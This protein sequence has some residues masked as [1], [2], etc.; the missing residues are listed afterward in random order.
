MTE[1][2]R[3]PKAASLPNGA[4]VMVEHSQPASGID[5]LRSLTSSLVRQH[6][7]V[8]VRNAGIDVTEFY[9]LVESISP[10]IKRGVGDEE[11]NLHLHGELY[12]L[13]A[14][15]D[16]LWFYCVVPPH[17]RGQTIL[18]DGVAVARQLKASTRFF[19]EA[20]PLE[21]KFDSPRRV[22]AELFGDL[23]IEQAAATANATMGA[24]CD[25]LGDGAEFSCEPVSNDVLRGIFRR[26]ALVTT[27]WGREPAFVNS[28]L[29]ALGLT[30]A[31][32]NGYSLNTDIP[33]HVLDDVDATTARLTSEIEWQAGDFAVLDNSR[34]M[35]GRR[36]FTGERDIRAVNGVLPAREQ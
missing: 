12:Y 26:C 3:V 20:T 29:L 7:G 25:E 27:R 31:N 8:V 5:E 24:V 11:Q 1:Q 14:K 9:A 32:T 34:M 10:G 33:S 30:A 6:G 15:L 17:D 21:Y 18:C 28:M 35:H 16:L 23:P 36:T 2:H 4:G 22:W 13:P 19:F